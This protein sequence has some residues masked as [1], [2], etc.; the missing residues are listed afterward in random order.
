M[1]YYPPMY[2]GWKARCPRQ[3]CRSRTVATFNVGP[4]PDWPRQPHV[5]R[6][7]VECLFAWSESLPEAERTDYAVQLS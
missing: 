6:Q 3:T 7:C 1:T 4:A 5:R 2:S